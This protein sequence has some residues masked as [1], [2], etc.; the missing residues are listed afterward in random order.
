MNR[1]HRRRLEREE[2]QKVERDCLFEEVPANSKSNKKDKDGD[3]GE[4]SDDSED[5]AES[6]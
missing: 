4:D 2:E 6:M 1:D 5:I 3:K